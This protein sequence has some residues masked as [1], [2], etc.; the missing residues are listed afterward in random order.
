MKRLRHIAMWILLATFVVGGALGPVVH[1]TQHA[2]EQTSASSH[3]HGATDGPVW[4]G[5]PVDVVAPDC[6]LCTTRLVVVPSAMGR[7]ALPHV[8][9]TAWDV[10][11]AHLT[12]SNVV[13][14]PFIRGP[15][16]V[17]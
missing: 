13:A 4:C 3:I 5:E 7:P 2:A 9:A 16:T 6:V 14:V 11:R 10:R 12:S 17:G 1:R 8:L 15:P